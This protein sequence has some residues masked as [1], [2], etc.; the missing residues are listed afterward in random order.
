MEKVEEAAKI[1]KELG[2][3]EKQQNE[4]S[5]LTLLALCNIRKTSKWKDAEAICMSVVGNKKNA[6]YPGIIRYISKY[7]KKEYAENSRETIRRQTLHQFIQAGIV[8]QNPENPS[9][10]TNSKDNHYKLTHEALEVIK[11]FRTRKWKTELKKWRENH[12]ALKDKY[13]KEREKKLIPLVLKNGNKLQ[14]SP[15]KHNELQIAIIEKFAPRFAPDSFLVYVGDTARKSLYIDE[16]I[17]QEIGIAFDEHKKLPDV[18]LFD[19]KKNWLFLIEAVTSHGPISPKR[20][21]ELETV[22]KNIEISKIYVSAFPDLDEFK[23]NAKDISW[24]TEIWIMN[25]PDHMIH[26]NGDKFLG[27]Y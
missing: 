27:P 5:S 11:S 26:F 6:K 17:L 3:P 16:K 9:L 20:L 1:L 23:K 2:L 10:P 22:F 21:T 18:I 15:G 14:F 4:R 12:I 25:V 8:V 7:Y 19:K 13:R 24:E